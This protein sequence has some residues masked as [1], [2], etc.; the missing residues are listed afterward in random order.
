MALASL[1]LHRFFRLALTRLAPL[2][3]L[4][5]STSCYESDL[6]S[7]DPTVALNL[8]GIV[9]TRPQVGPLVAT[10]S[11]IPTITFSAPEL[12]HSG[13]FFQIRMGAPRKP[14]GPGF[15]SA[16]LHVRDAP[17]A[18][19]LG[20]A[21]F[22]S[23]QGQ[24]NDDL[25]SI[26]IRGQLRSDFAGEK[27]NYEV[28]IGLLDANGMLGAVKIW[29]PILIGKTPASCPADAQ[30]LS[31][32]C[33]FESVCGTYC[34]ENDGACQ[35]GL[36][37]SID[38]H[39][40]PVGPACPDAADCSARSC[41]P[42]PVC[43]ASCGSCDDGFSC[44]ES[45]SCIESDST[46]T[47][48]DDTS[49]TDDACDVGQVRCN[50]MCI[51]PEND[52]R[53]CGAR[54][55]CEGADAGIKCDVTQRCALGVCVANCSGGAVDCGGTCIDPDNDPAHC[56]AS[57]PCATNPGMVCDSGQVC[58][59]ASCEESCAA[60]EVL[61]DGRCIDPD[62][63]LLHCG[64]SL[65]CQDDNA[66]VKCADTQ[67]C[68][69]GICRENCLDTEVLCDG[70]CIDPK[71]DADYCGANGDCAGTNA[72]AVCKSGEVC[73]DATC[74]I[75]CP[76]A[77]LLCGGECVDPQKDSD[78]C[79]ATNSCEGSENGEKCTG[80]ERCE[81]GKCA[82]PCGAGG[83]V[84]CDSTCIDP[85]TDPAWCGAKLDCEGGNAGVSCSPDAT[86]KA[87]A[88]VANCA[89]GQVWC[90][91]ACIDPLS[92]RTYCGA[93]GP[94][95]SGAKTCA[96]EAFC[97]AG[98]CEGTPAECE[99]VI[100][101]PDDTLRAEIRKIVGMS[102]DLTFERLLQIKELG[103]TDPSV[104][105]PRYSNLQGV[106]CLRNLQFYRSRVYSFSD[107]E[108]APIWK[109]TLLTSLEVV[110]DNGADYSLDGISNLSR[111]RSLYL[112]IDLTSY[113]QLAGLT[114]LSSLTLHQAIKSRSQMS[115]E[116]TYA[117]A[118]DLSPFSNLVNLTELNIEPPSASITD[119]SAL[120]DLRN[121]KKLHL[122]ST[123]LPSA[124]FLRN[125]T[126]L[127]DLSLNGNNFS[128]SSPLANLRAM[129][130]LDLGG[131]MIGSTAFLL[132][133]P[134]IEVL[135]LYGN[136]IESISNLSGL[137]KLKELYLGG[138]A[139]NDA[140]PLNGLPLLT[141]LDLGSTSVKSTKLPTNLPALTNIFLGNNGLTEINNLK[142]LTKLTSIFLYNNNISD[143]RPLQNLNLD[144]LNITGNALNCADA[145]TTAILN[146]I[147]A[148]PGAVVESDCAP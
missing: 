124:N 140:T 101:I 72:G 117:A 52:P 145:T 38:Q 33:G 147:R 15:A 87:G 137:V 56:G 113:E 130:R 99:G 85:K 68:S 98:A 97:I 86:C 141:T 10:P 75:D 118:I 71:S 142:D 2:T 112:A 34:G 143:I 54:E 55:S 136:N 119:A 61:C 146:A 111:L 94:D 3:A 133:M 109:L 21:A 108:L 1:A 115:Q 4:A 7:N 64:A 69:G 36:S 88:C 106:S 84:M 23:P 48:T 76:D 20:A 65:D 22:P 134:N 102:G 95:C 144:E 31:A 62:N 148:K 122:W 110:S 16:I 131:N 45:G 126:E 127:E 135:I 129:R 40:L 28:E 81:A 121:L 14:G 91:G 18:F 116:P 105:A 100:D 17:D 24:G 13:D 53:Y 92:D 114:N 83:D 90:G 93:T 60:N 79:G 27:K 63:D 43:G 29:R 39:C 30:C 59:H 125:L 107:A 67:V 123:S 44:T 35:P 132:E 47:S 70:H 9:G 58:S 11:G 74:R 77:L 57:E 37:C 8:D 49:S 78:F 6:P 89:A 104:G 139:I 138:N 51:D 41:G 42:D 66:G 46:D 12:L 32:Q 25:W 19:L 96:P 26:D 82:N 73:V 50:E 120:S 80:G 128:D 103:P 5:L